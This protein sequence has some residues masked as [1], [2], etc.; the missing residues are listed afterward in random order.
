MSSDNMLDSGI[1]GELRFTVIEKDG[2]RIDFPCKWV[3]DI[4]NEENPTKVYRGNMDY[5][6]DGIDALTLYRS[7]SR[8]TT[9]LFVFRGSVFKTFKWT[10]YEN[11]ENCLY[12]ATQLV[13]NELPDSD[14][15]VSQSPL[16]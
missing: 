6:V 5:S 1:V 13:I 8:G 16:F 2:T 9:I 4:D 3:P 15:V 7:V 10:S 12:H 14:S 11:T